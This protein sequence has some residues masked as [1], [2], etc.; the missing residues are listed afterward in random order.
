MSLTAPEAL[1]LLLQAHARQRLAHAYLL[2]G[3]EH[4][5]KRELAAQLCGHLLGVPPEK[6]LAH[7]DVH[8]IAPESKSRGLLT[9]QIRE[10]ESQIQM[11]SSQG[12]LKFGI[13]LDADRLT[14]SAANAFLKT[15]EEPPPGTHLLLL[16]AQPGQLPPTI[17]S[18]CE[19]IQL[20][21]IS[22]PPRSEPE[23][24]LLELIN[25]YFRDKTPSLASSLSLAQQLQSLLASTKDQL[26]QTMESEAKAT[27]QRYKQ[28][29]DARWL[30]QQEEALAARLEAAYIGER[31]RLLELLEAFWADV[32][33]IQQGL[34]GSHLPECAPAIE[35]LA[36][37]LSPA[38]AHR[39]L[40]PISRMRD[41]LG[42]SGV[43]EALA[44][45]CGLLESLFPEPA[46][47]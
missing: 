38:Q 26:R 21:W 44:L 5:G 2:T 24:K 18:R 14:D 43:S 17:L 45:E 28:M 10:L 36:A 41:Q 39:R 9:D 22:R 8:F 32:L 15:L 11:R 27:A 1:Q 35:T 4:S 16:S 47:K 42:R 25:R 19:E 37:S 6:A 3:P 33:R 29:V 13:L 34:S 23:T 46:D 30:E 7:P 40:G 31:N 20:R 12:G